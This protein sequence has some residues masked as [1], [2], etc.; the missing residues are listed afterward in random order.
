M[1]VKKITEV[2]VGTARVVDGIQSEARSSS[3]GLKRAA[4]TTPPRSFT[5]TISEKE[6]LNFAIRCRILVAHGV[7]G[8]LFFSTSYTSTDRL[9]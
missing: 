9:Q 2:I 5:A 1:G 6:L 8:P 4:H 7:A 3:G